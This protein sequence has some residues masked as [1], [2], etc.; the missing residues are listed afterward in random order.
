MPAFNIVMGVGRREPLTRIGEIAA[1]VEDLGFSGLWI[2]D[3]PLTTK[4]PYMALTIAALKTKKIALGPGVSNPITR[5]PSVIVN[6]IFSLDQLSEGRAVLGLGNGGPALVRAFGQ[7]PRR[8]VEFRQDLIEIRSLLR[9]EEVKVKGGDGYRISGIER[10]IPMYVAARGPRVLRLAGELADG[11]LIAGPAQPDVLQK[12]MQAVKDGAVDTG[13]DPSEVRVNLLTNMAVDTDPEKAI[14]TVRPFAV[15]AMIEAAKPGDE[16]PPQYEH[17]FKQIHESHDPTKHL[18]AGSAGRDL[19]PDDLAK[20]V[21]IAGD[22]NECRERLQ[23][24]IA[25][26]PDE[27]TLTLMTG[28]RMERLQS[29]ARV[30][31]GGS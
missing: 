10:P 16:I 2:Q 6:S 21:A 19:I 29:F 27:I 20:F 13:R 8:I 12:K 1:V 22:E 31:F 18:A 25:I 17:V 7:S 23:S 24:I 9:G 15:G 28:G 3:N 26:G 4:D 14:D 5:H 30:A 11:V